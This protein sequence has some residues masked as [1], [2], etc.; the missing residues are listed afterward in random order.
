[1]KG[2]LIV[3]EG[4]DG[5]GKTTQASMLEDQLMKN[6][7]DVRWEREPTDGPVGRM[8]RNDLLSGNECVAPIVMDQLFLLDRED[9]MSA[10]TEYLDN[11]VT[12]ICDRYVLSSLVYR[13]AWAIEQFTEKAFNTMMLG[14]YVKVM[15][16][17]VKPVTPDLTI[18]IDTKPETAMKRLSAR[19][20]EKSIYETMNKLNNIYRTYDVALNIVTSQAINI[21][22]SESYTINR[23]GDLDLHM[24]NRNSTVIHPMKIIRIDGETDEKSIHETTWSLV[25]CLVKGSED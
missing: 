2:K 7:I 19:G 13:T 15:L 24:S 8:L 3:F 17:D 14:E 6:G 16:T 1:M 4:I 10:I 18:Y 5:S 11:G 9:H 22:S 20:G 21:S 12:V 23:S 25:R